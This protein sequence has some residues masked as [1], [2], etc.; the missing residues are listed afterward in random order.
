[1]PII[2]VKFLIIEEEVVLSCYKRR[3]GAGRQRYAYKPKPHSLFSSLLSSS[4]LQKSLGFLFLL[5][6]SPFSLRRNLR[7]GH[8]VDNYEILEIIIVLAKGFHNKTRDQL[9]H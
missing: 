5:E 7:K 9:L 4:S 2:E 3:R 1:M 8:S 6:I